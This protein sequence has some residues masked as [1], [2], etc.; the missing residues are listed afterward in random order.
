MV[1]APQMRG[2]LGHSQLAGISLDHSSLPRELFE[3]A[4]NKKSA[5]SLY[6]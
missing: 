3:E 5:D 4:E 6:F 1:S 2:H